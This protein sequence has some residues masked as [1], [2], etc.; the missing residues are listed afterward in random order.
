[1]IGFDMY[2]GKVTLFNDSCTS[3]FACFISEPA[4]KNKST[5]E[6]PS[7]V[8]E[9]TEVFLFTPVT[10]LSIGVVTSVSIVLE[11]VPCPIEIIVICG[12]SALGKNS[13]G[14]LK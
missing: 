2:G 8:V 14:S 6:K 9:D 5:F 12:L 3:S 7:P 11:S 4:S 10:A 1:M 13:I